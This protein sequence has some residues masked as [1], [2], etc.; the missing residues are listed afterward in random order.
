MERMAVYSD[1]HY[2]PKIART[3]KISSTLQSLLYSYDLASETHPLDENGKLTVLFAGDSSPMNRLPRDKSFSVVKNSFDN[4][5]KVANSAPN[6]NFETSVVIGNHEAYGL[7]LKDYNFFSKDCAGID[8]LASCAIPIKNKPRSEI[9]FASLR[10]KLILKDDIGYFV[11]HFPLDIRDS[12]L[13][14]LMN[15]F[16]LEALVGVTGHKHEGFVSL[17]TRLL[18]EG[19]IYHVNI[20][21]FTQSAKFVR[22]KDLKGLDF[23][24]NGELIVMDVDKN[25]ISISER[26]VDP[27][28][29]G[30]KEY[31]L[32]SL[33]TSGSGSYSNIQTPFKRGILI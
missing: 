6:N 15:Q 25:S 12:S 3:S 31:E 9:D 19:T 28:D 8:L 27:A 29:Y 16:G 11:Q 7:G 2:N 20:P 23:S 30:I 26:I 21:A 18:S 10:Q 17:D 5:I 22:R 33:S 4:V 24:V 1:V 13:V 32:L 14:G